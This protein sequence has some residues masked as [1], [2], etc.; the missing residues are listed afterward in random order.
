MTA[1]FL[2]IDTEFAWRHQQAGH[3]C[4]G[5]YARSVEPAGVGLTYQLSV[6]AR[7]GLKACF[8]IDP[9]P[10]MAFGLAPIRRMVDAVLAAGQEVQLHLHPAWTA[11]RSGDRGRVEVRHELCEYERA[12]Q[13]DLIAGAAELLVAAGAPAPIAFRAG[14]YGADDTTLAVLTEL[15]FAYDSSHNGAHQPWPSR[16]GL[17]PRRIAPVHRDLIEIPVTLIEDVPGNLRTV[18]ICALSTAELRDTLDHAAAGDHAALTIVSHSFELANREGSRPNAVHVRRFE[19]LCAMLAA[20]RADLPTCRFDER[21]PLALNRDDRPLPPHRM[22]TAWR[23]TEQL[24]SNWVEE[25]AA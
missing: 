20:R 3:D 22:R 8:F 6:L 23:R 14:S 24:W 18:Q 16:I 13:R 11:A 7:H 21:P 9:M 19:A 1:V 25:R 10:A 5:I 12:E 2:T 17:D 15:G 4:E